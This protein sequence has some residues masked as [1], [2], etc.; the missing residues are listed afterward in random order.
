MVFLTLFA[1]IITADNTKK[2]P[3]LA[4]IAIAQ[5]EKNIKEK[6]LPNKPEPKISNATPKL[7][8]EEIPKTKGPA[9]GFLNRVCINNPQIDRPEPTIIAVSAL[10]NLKFKMMVCQVFLEAIPPVKKLKI[11]LKGIDTEPKLMFI[12]KKTIRRMK[13]IIKYFV[14]FLEGLN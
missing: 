7:A 3:K 13:R 4:A 2:E 10:G 14:Y 9:N 1:A 11:S 5:L 12:K 6:T 8:P